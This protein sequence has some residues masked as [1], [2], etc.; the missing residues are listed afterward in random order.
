MNVVKQT[1]GFVAYG[2][3]PLMVLAGLAE[4]AEAQG[5]SDAIP[6]NASANS[7]GRGLHRHRIT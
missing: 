7:Y 3:M 6:A 1:L 2:L 4:F 5:V